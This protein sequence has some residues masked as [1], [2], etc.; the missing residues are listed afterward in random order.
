M[1]LSLVSISRADAGAQVEDDQFRWVAVTNVVDPRQ[2]NVGQG[3]NVHIAC[4]KLLL[5][6]PYLGW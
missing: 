4:Q 2:A 3:F 6:E 5:D 1:L